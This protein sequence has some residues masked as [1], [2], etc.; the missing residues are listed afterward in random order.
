MSDLKRQICSALQNESR[1]VQD[2]FY[3][4]GKDFSLKDLVYNIETEVSFIQRC[5]EAAK[6]ALS[7]E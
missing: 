7:H 3:G 6:E 1:K 2:G 4:E 5:I